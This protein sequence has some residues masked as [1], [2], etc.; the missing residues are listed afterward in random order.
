MSRPKLRAADG[1]RFYG[2]LE[3]TEAGWRA[4]GFAQVDQGGKI[5]TD[6]PEAFDAETRP[7]A[8]T[9]LTQTALFRG[10]TCWHDLDRA[11]VQLRR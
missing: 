7:E 10:F 3:R 9:W 5:L 2:R 4:S 6:E 11:E 8:V 1:A